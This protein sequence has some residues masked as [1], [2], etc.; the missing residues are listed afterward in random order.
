MRTLPQSCALQNSS[1]TVFRRLT[2][3]E[4]TIPSSPICTYLSRSFDTLIPC[5]YC[6]LMRPEDPAYNFKTTS[7]QLSCLVEQYSLLVQGLLCLGTVRYCQVEA[8]SVP[9]RDCIVRTK[10]SGDLRRV[11][12]IPFGNDSCVVA[13]HRIAQFSNAVL[14]SSALGLRQNANEQTK[15][16]TIVQQLELCL[17]LVHTQ[18]E[19]KVQTRHAILARHR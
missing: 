15:I 17:H 16:V 6:L 10:A 18:K 12:A 4:H 11:C 19:S 5:T 8:V 14:P 1:A 13:A 7:C 2:T 9:R 3:F